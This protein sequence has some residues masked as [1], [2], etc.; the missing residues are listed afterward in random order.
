MGPED[1][2]S[3]EPRTDLSR[4]R[5]TGTEGTHR[6]TYLAEGDA[7]LHPQSLPEQYFLGLPIVSSH[8]TVTVQFSNQYSPSRKPRI[9]QSP[10]L[11][12]TVLPMV[13][14]SIKNCS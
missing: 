2:S 11:P 5:L 9:S 12:G 13:S 6:W 1:Q 7:K 8:L 4:W 10:K 14:C 3:F